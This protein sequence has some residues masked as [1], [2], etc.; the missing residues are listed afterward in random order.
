MSELLTEVVSASIKTDTVA[1]TDD[2]IEKYEAIINQNITNKTLAASKNGTVPQ[3]TKEELAYLNK[4]SDNLSEFKVI[5]PDPTIILKKGNTEINIKNAATLVRK[6]DELYPS[7]MTEDS[8]EN[9]LRQ[10]FVKKSI[11]YGL[12]ESEKIE[13]DFTPAGISI[14]SPA[15]IKSV[16]KNAYEIRT[17]ILSMALGWVQYK[18]QMMSHTASFSPTDEDVLTTAHKF[19]KFVEKR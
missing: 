7:G 6:M 2:V 18:G 5:T 19:Y 11:E 12:K 4:K 16:N 15:E 8:K 3:F 10:P 9:I 17:D 14:V 1:S 13:P